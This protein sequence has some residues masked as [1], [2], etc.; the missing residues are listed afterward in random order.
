MVC[1]R[2]GHARKYGVTI[3]NAPG[4]IDSGFRGEVKVILHNTDKKEAFYVYPGMRIAQLVLTG[5]AAG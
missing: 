3:V 1:P 5:P 2:S 4:I